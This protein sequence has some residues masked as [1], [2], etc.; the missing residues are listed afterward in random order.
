[1]P[2]KVCKALAQP[3]IEVGCDPAVRDRLK[4][5]KEDIETKVR[6]WLTVLETGNT[7]AAS[8]P[9]A[10]A[11]I[12]DKAKFGDDILAVSYGS[13]AYTIATW[14]TVGKEINKKRKS[15]L[16]VQDYIQ[17]KKEVDFK[18]YDSYLKERTK[19]EKTRLEYPRIIGDIKPIGKE[20]IKIIICSSCNRVYYPVRN[21]CLNFECTGNLD[22]ITFPIRAKLK[23]ISHRQQKIFNSNILKK[24]KVFIVDADVDELKPGIELECVIRRLD[25]EGSDGLIIYGPC[26][27]P[28]FR[29]N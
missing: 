27:R 10:I 12:L 9:I 22:K 25:Y 26:Y 8:T 16:G 13:G 23:K 29:K 2:L 5:S 18:T 11:T 3:K 20:S 17:R 21:R 24:G 15:V 7:Y 6:P 19:R 14:L 4:I 1:M 28:S